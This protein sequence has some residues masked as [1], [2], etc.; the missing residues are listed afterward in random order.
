MVCV[1]FESAE[2]EPAERTQRKTAH[3]FF[4]AGKAPQK[5]NG[6]FAFL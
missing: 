2:I 6:R 4:Q 3:C 1:G 5:G